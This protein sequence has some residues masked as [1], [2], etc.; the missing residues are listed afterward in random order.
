MQLKKCFVH[1]S[2]GNSSQFS[3]LSPNADTHQLP[4]LNM[5]DFHGLSPSKPR[6]KNTK[7][8]RLSLD[9]VGKPG[10]SPGLA[11]GSI[12]PLIR[13]RERLEK[14]TREMGKRER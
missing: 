5:V 11:R 4:M 6:P 7:T 8:P 12:L 3:V 9:C 1:S 14:W 2:F 10:S 13:E